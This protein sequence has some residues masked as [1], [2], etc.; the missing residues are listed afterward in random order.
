VPA[1]AA[2]RR[3]AACRGLLRETLRGVARAPRLG[4]SAMLCAALGVAAV[5]AVTTL[6]L[7]TLVRPLPFPEPARLV[8]IW[9]A[10]D[11]GEARGSLSIPELA[12][13]E[14][15]PAF[16]RVLG[17]ARQRMVA[18]L[19]GGAERLRGEAVSASYFEILGV[20][21][22]LGRGF[23]AGDH[24]ADAAR[25]ALL[26]HA[27]WR[28]RFGGGADVLGRALASETTSYEIVG[29]LPPDFAGTV[30]QDV[31]DFWVPIGQYGH[32]AGLTDRDFRSMWAIGVLRPG[33]TLAQAQEQL[34]A[35]GAR[36]LREHPQ[37]YARRLPYA[38]PL[39]ENWR[40]TFRRSGAVLLAAALALLVVAML[41][42]GGLFLARALERR[43]ELAV[44]AALGASPAA[45]AA[46]LAGEAFLLVG[47]GGLLGAAAATPLLRAFLAL[48]P[49]QLPAYV[50]VTADWRA[51]SAALLTIL[52]A[53]V[54][55]G[56]LPLVAARRVDPAA[57][58]N[59]ARG[60]VGARGER[61][62]QSL[63]VGS[64]V[65]LTLIVLFTGGLLLR[66]FARLTGLDLGYRVEGVA[67]LS[68]TA[69]RDV[70]AAGALPDF[71]RRLAEELAAHPGVERLG[72]VWRTLP[73]WDADRADIQVDGLDPALAERGVGVGLHAVDP[74]FLR[75]LEIPLVAGRNVR[76]GDDPEAPPVALVSRSLARLFAGEPEAA[77][78]SVIRLPAEA[79]MRLAAARVVGVVEDVLYDGVGEQGTGRYIHYAPSADSTAALRGGAA[80]DPRGGRLDLYLSLAQAGEPIVSIAA[81]TAGDPEALLE[82]L[83]R[84]VAAIEPRAAVH[85]TGTMASALGEE[86]AASRF[87]LLVVAAFAFGALALTAV[88][89]FALCANALARRSGEIGVR[90][91]LGASGPA[92]TRLVLCAGLGPIAAGALAGTGAALA[93]GRLARG[94]L[95]GVSAADPVVLAAGGLLL[96]GV[97][98]LASLPPA[99]RAA[100]VD[101][102]VALRGDG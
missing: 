102:L 32:P 101:P 61:R 86:V 6:V 42:T 29:V 55:A 97:A 14:A 15:L 88:G 44:R 65:A 3:L 8:R 93:A 64:Q 7:A 16:A 31:V 56:S 22:L 10:E 33:A 13:L 58:F 70:V 24:A 78:G 46:R 51:L 11:G 28:Q 50:A 38:E 76:P 95:Y 94:L 89:V 90:L 57:L 37:I 45:L 82:P 68:V 80:I 35:A 12:D 75:A 48:S 62:W 96:V 99:R 40:G 52:A 81:V 87:F 9:F 54:L 63:L 41:D 67:R 79:G 98:L 4:L 1:N 100:R 49:V 17:T 23:V 74:G 73:P 84:R 5:T 91:A 25:V 59:R 19:P 2:I 53:G 39:G 85:W 47:A 36:L 34:A 20:R 60:A 66:S 21:P 92:I 83:R 69:S 27:T 30:E 18:L 43:G 26:S 72:L 77:L 71:Q